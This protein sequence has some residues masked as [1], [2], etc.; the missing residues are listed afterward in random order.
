MLLFILLEVRILVI[1]GFVPICSN[2]IVV[3]VILLGTHTTG[4]EL[5]FRDSCDAFPGSCLRAENYVE[6]RA[7]FLLQ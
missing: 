1:V 5:L 3:V 4:F 6:L 2:V 7:L